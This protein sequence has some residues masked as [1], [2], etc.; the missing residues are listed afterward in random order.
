MIEIKPEAKW[1]LKTQTR[2]SGPDSEPAT[3]KDGVRQLTQ[4]SSK[5]GDL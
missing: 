2:S 5:P 4:M 3:D 1:L